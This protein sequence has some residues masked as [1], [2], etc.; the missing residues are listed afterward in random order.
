MPM[1]KLFHDVVRE[2]HSVRKFLPTPAPDA[3]RGVPPLTGTTLGLA[4]WA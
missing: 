3:L 4:P 1:L 2:R